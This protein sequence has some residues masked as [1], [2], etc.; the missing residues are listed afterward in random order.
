MVKADT[1]NVQGLLEFVLSS[2]EIQAGAIHYGYIETN[3]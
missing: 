2:P 3:S 1:L